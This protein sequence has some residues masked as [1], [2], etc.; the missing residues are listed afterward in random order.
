MEEIKVIEADAEQLPQEREWFIPLMDWGG[1]GGKWCSGSA[2]RSKEDAIKTIR[3]NSTPGTQARI[4][5][6][7]LPFKAIA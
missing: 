5:R 7:V 1:D 4:I 2:F 6:V 3:D